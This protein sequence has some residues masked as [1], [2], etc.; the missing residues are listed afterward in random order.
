VTESGTE[1][2]HRKL[3]TKLNR[4][5]RSRELA[6]R[7]IAKL[8]AELR[9]MRQETVDRLGLTEVQSERLTPLVLDIL[10][11]VNPVGEC[12]IWTGAHNNKGL[13]RMRDTRQEPQVERSACVLLD[14]MLNDSD[15]TGIRYP[16][17]RSG[18]ACVNPSHKR[19]RGSGRQWH[20]T[21][22][23]DGGDAYREAQ[24]S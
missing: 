14:M 12:W 5:L 17:C 7:K 8:S 16:N 20:G 6:N 3:E 19:V 18:R 2:R 10:D 11:R 15:G 23:F 4:A 24:A 1:L 21:G 13:P 22:A 9:R